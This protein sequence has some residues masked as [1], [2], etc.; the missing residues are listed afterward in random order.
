MLRF[1]R[2]RMPVAAERPASSCFP[3][4]SVAAVRPSILTVF[5]LSSYAHG[6][7]ALTGRF[8]YRAY[9]VALAS[10]DFGLLRT[11]CHRSAYSYVSRYLFT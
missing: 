4:Y 5:L 2:F 6:R 10:R 7:Y 11:T 1:Y 8:P 3:A 9:S